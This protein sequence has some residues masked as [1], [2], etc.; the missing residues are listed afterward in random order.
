MS[1]TSLQFP[2]IFLLIEGGALLVSCPTVNEPR[3]TDSPTLVAA[4]TT[5]LPMA[6]VLLTAAATPTP[7]PRRTV[8]GLAPHRGRERFFCL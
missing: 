4:S 3:A 1:K 6:T 7:L 2:M 8:P 5:T